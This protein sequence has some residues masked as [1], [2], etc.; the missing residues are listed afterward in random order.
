MR[1][2]LDAL[3]TLVAIAEAGSFAGAAERLHKVPS[4]LTYTVNKLESDLGVMLFDRNAKRAQLT[5]AGQEL[6]ARGRELLGQAVN[7]EARVKR[8]AQGWEAHLAV[9]VDGVV[10]LEQ[11]LPLVSEFDALHGGTRLRFTHE[12]FG[13]TW[14]ALIDRRADLAVGA[15]GD[16]PGGYGLC[17][18]ELA[19][20]EFIYAVAP[21]HPLADAAEPIPASLRG[22]YRAVAVADSSR[23]LPA[24]TEG[25]VP[26]QEMLLVPTLQSKLQAQLL[27]L[28]SGFLPAY[29]ARAEAAAGRLVIKQTT[30]PR[31]PIQLRIAWRSD[32]EGRALSWFRDRVLEEAE[33]GRLLPL[34]DSTAP[35]ARQ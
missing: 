13:G 12:I 2:S 6:L 31:E 32:E 28:G 9:A 33:A 5:A 35:A 7:L 29:M 10:P 26:D 17:S 30:P 21:F 22:R 8:V 3:E 4:A 20:I 23:R 14:D 1:L 19:T 18:R 16:P 24:R 34:A 25:L 11:L 15:G 27:G